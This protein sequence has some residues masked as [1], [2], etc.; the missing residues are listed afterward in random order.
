MPA[1]KHVSWFFFKICV[2]YGFFIVVD[3]GGVYATVF[4]AFGNGAYANMGDRGRVRLIKAPPEFPDYDTQVKLI[5][6]KIRGAR[7]TMEIATRKTAYLPTAFTIALVLATPIPIKRRAIG[8]IIALAMIGGF[9]LFQY[10]LQFVEVLSRQGPLDVYGL[11]SFVRGA[12]VIL[13]KILSLTPV[14]AYIIPV[15][16]WAIV[17]FRRDQLAQLTALCRGEEATHLSTASQRA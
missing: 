10:Y 11:S 15:I 12:V 9:V 16:I 7:G 3:C 5:N 14:T 13:I 2:I 6:G 1:F 8:L 4:R 17:I